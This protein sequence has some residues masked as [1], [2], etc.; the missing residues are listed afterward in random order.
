MSALAQDFSLALE[1][2]KMNLIADQPYKFGC[3]LL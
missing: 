2:I 3:Q 1:A